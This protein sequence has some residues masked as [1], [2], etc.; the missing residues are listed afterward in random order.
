M[1]RTGVATFAGA[2][3]ALASLALGCVL[4]TGSTDGYNPPPQPTSDGGCTRNADCTGGGACCIQFEGTTPVGEACQPNACASEAIH[5]CVH[6]SDCGD[7]GS[8]LT[9]SCN[10][11]ALNVTFHTCAGIDVPGCTR[12]TPTDAATEASIGDAAGDAAEG[13]AD[14]R[15]D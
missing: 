1:A 10:V 4:I 7:A 6:D 13:G 14:A 15:T 2:L 5:L 11:G 12:T 3:G 8:C 9:Q